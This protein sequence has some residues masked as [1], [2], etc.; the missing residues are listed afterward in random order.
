MFRRS[1]KFPLQSI[2]LSLTKVAQI[3]F[4]FAKGTPHLLT[5][6]PPLFELL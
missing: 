5:E 3:I 6:N 2:A 4:S 1:I